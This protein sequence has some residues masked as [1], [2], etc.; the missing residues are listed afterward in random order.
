MPGHQLVGMH[1]HVAAQWI[2]AERGRMRDPSP[3]VREITSSLRL[4]YAKLVKM[5]LASA[6]HS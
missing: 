4:V 2:D 6:S 5:R 3:N 1:V